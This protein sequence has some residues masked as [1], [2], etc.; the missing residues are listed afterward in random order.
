MLPLAGQTPQDQDHHIHP[1]TANTDQLAVSGIGRSFEVLYACVSG[2]HLGSAHL[3][4]LQLILVDG[5]GCLLWRSRSL[6]LVLLTHRQTGCKGFMPTNTQMKLTQQM[7]CL[8]SVAMGC[9]V[10]TG[11]ARPSEV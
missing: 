8:T 5:N 7:R 9:L 6:M 1:D 2:A 4:L 3:L 10:A 11:L